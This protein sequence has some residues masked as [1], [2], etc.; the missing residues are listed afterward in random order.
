MTLTAR[1]A[2]V[3]EC[4]EVAV[5]CHSLMDLDYRRCYRAGMKLRLCLTLFFLACL[6]V[7]GGAEPEYRIGMPCEVRNCD[8]SP[9]G[10]VVEEAYRRI[11]VRVRFEVLPA[12]RELDYANSGF[13]DGCLARTPGVAGAYPNLVQVPFPLLRDTIVACSVRDGIDVPDIEALQRYRV[14]ILHGAHEVRLL[15]ERAGVVPDYY[16][17]LGNG[18]RM[19]REGR[20]DVMLEQ[21]VPLENV[22]REA[23]VSVR[24]SV[25]LYLGYRY[26]WLNRRSAGIADDLARVLRE[27]TEDGTTRR[28]LGSYAG[29]AVAPEAV[30]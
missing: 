9:V 13:L 10:R 25:P 20:I 30:D 21:R 12:L 22:A 7:P 6:T 24:F 26:H 18:L 1:P 29:M 28:L 17:K 14:G 4:R 19:L 3:N 23:G 16:N 8:V 5:K 11:G 15:C 2:F 27:M